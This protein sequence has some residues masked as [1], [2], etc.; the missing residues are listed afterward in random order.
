MYRTGFRVVTMA[1]AV[2]VVLSVAGC[3]QQRRESFEAKQSQ[4]LAEDQALT[5]RA[6]TAIDASLAKG[7]KCDGP[8][9][10]SAI[11]GLAALKNHLD[12]FDMQIGVFPSEYVGAQAGY[13]TLR[14]NLA[15]RAKAK[16][17]LD[18][19]DQQ[20]RSVVTAY[21]GSRQ[22]A[23]YWERARLGVE[24]VREARRSGK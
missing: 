8:E 24:D 1:Q 12:S 10:A 11:D 21:S 17:C 18:L 19:A 16:G 4:L 23:S 6:G 2:A 15:D 22:W 5:H 14:L 13:I 9:V 20:Y 3:A 7:V